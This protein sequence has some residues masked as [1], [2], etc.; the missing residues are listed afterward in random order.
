MKR[1]IDEHQPI[2]EQRRLLDLADALR[3]AP[4]L[5][6]DTEFVRE[7]T[8][9]PKLCLIQLASEETI[10]CVD[11]LAELD[12]E[13]LFESLFAPECV[14]VLHSARQDL[15]VIWNAAR[16]LPSRLID[17]QI[18]AGLLGFAPQIGLQELLAGILQVDLD[19]NHARTDWTRRPLPTQALRYALD[20]VRYLLPA[21][22]QLAERL[23]ALG[24]LAWQEEDCRRLLATPP[25]ADPLTIWQRLRGLAAMSEERR[26]AAMALVL[27][28]EEKARKLDRPRRWILSDAHLAAIAKAMPRSLDELQTIEALPP[29][30]VSRSGRELVAAIKKSTRASIRAS[31]ASVQPAQKPD[32][33]QLSVLQQQVQERARELGIQA[34]IIASRRDLTALALGDA[35]EH[36]ASGWRAE[37][38]R[39]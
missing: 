11:C 32:K 9:Y 23:Q 37:Q 36:L 12:L 19:K 3:Q 17:T 2:T 34:E 18:A 8:Y 15:E 6:V 21:W 4:L 24:R 10:A 35:P 16:R 30:L 28:R 39:R 31:V 7:S 25:T 26:C 38:L 22:R 20:D 13:P 5:A 29:R 27:W 33:T 14:W 1:D